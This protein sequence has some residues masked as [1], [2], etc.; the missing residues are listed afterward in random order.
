[1]RF[2]ISRHLSTIYKYF[3]YER[4]ILLRRHVSLTFRNITRTSSASR[5]M[6]F[7]EDFRREACVTKLCSTHART[8]DALIDVHG[9]NGGL[10]SALEIPARPTYVMN[11]RFAT[12]IRVQLVIESYRERAFL[13]LRKSEREKVF[14][15]RMHSKRRHNFHTRITISRKF[16]RQLILHTMRI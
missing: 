8:R 3:D 15:L 4:N 11:R 7:R 16:S 9:A 5:C 10:F 6:R 14:L 12:K 1:M 13:R 2:S